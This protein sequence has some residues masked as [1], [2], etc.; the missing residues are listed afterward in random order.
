MKNVK[1]VL[2]SLWR[3]EMK[4]LLITLML[5]A[6]LALSF[7]CAVNVGGISVEKIDDQS[8][9]P[10]VPPDNGVIVDEV[11]GIV[12]GMTL[13]ENLDAESPAEVYGDTLW[14]PGI[15]GTAMEFD[16]EGEYILL[17]DSPELDL[18]EQG[19]VEV[20]VYPYTNIAAA[21]IVHKGVELDYSDEAYSLQYNNPGQVAFIITNNDGKHTYVISNEATLTTEQ[22]H[23]IVAAWDLNDVYLYIDGSLVTNRSIYSNGWVTE[24]P[25]DFAPAKDSD[26]ALMIG[27]QIPYSYRFDGIIDNVYL[28][29]RVLEEAEVAEHYNSLIP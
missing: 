28:Y 14:V 10:V 27:S 9:E 4:K 12:A 29:D 19:T 7:S 25:L 21:G 8:E 3:C 2:Y 16:E 18:T 23:H 26:G 5:I 13:D 1:C 22:W 11:E 17:P 20:W 15:D 6:A 24:L